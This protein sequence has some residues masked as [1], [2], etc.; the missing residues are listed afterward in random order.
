MIEFTHLTPRDPEKVT[1]FLNV[2]LSKHDDNFQR[3]YAL[4][5]EMT[6][7]SIK[8]NWQKYGR[9]FLELVTIPQLKEELKLLDEKITGNKE[10]LIERLDEIWTKEKKHKK[11]M[12]DDISILRGMRQGDTEVYVMKLSIFGSYITCD[13]PAYFTFERAIQHMLKFINWND[14]RH[15]YVATFK[16]IE[17]HSS[18]ERNIQSSQEI[19]KTIYF[20]NEVMLRTLPLEPGD[21][22]C[23]L[24]NF[25]CN[26]KFKLQFV[27]IHFM[28]DFHK[29]E[30][31]KLH[32]MFPKEHENDPD[33]MINE[34][35]IIPQERV[36]K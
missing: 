21:C 29:V 27:D 14:F 17:I 5:D 33:T 10:D 31:I 19:G 8:E 22:I 18:F 2:H 12:M 23:L 25:L 30:L 13:V 24:F 4:V 3:K 15:Y 26:W 32:G 28:K 34:T 20:G 11:K 6:R 16:D 7:R 36:H 35:V 1:N 9:N